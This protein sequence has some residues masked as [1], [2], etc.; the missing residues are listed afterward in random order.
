LARR[1]GSLSTLGF[2]T[3]L[4]AIAMVRLGSIAEAEADA[5]QAL[6]GLPEGTRVPL[7]FILSP[8]IDALVERGELD[9]AAQLA[10]DNQVDDRPEQLRFALLFASI[11]RLRLAEGRAADAVELLRECGRRLEGSALRNPAF[12]EWR[13]SLAL[14]HAALGQ[15]D[16]AGE[17]AAEDV[18]LARGFEVPRALG[19]ALRT[20]ALVGEPTFRLDRLREAVAV[21]EQTV[22]PLELARTLTDLGAALR[23]DG[24]R[25]ESREPLRQ[26]LDLA[27]RCGA[28]ALVERAR[29][30]LRASGARPRRLVLTGPDALTVSERR[31]AEMAAKGLTNRRVA[32]ALFITE[33]TVEGHLQ[34]AY[35]KLG[36][37]SREQLPAALGISETTIRA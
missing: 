12:L 31:V 28:D 19:I 32:Q 18:A 7:P 20:E 34:H 10:A 29:T 11:G 9:A 36:I 4:R 17:L 15:A 2:A 21:L 22:A 1:T 13:S 35:R 24:R 37:R 6:E 26:G 27:H 14:A 23:R 33:K 5:R 3:T 25:V 30:E 16:E 8:L